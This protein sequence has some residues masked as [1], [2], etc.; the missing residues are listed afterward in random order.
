MRFG[1]VFS[2]LFA[3]ACRSDSDFNKI[4]DGN[5]GA[6]DGDSDT[7]ADV[8]DDPGTDTDD[9]EDS[10]TDDNEDS[11]TDDSG[12]DDSGTDDSGAD[13]DVDGDCEGASD[14]TTYFA[15][16]GPSLWEEAASECESK[17]MAFGSIRSTAENDF[18]TELMRGSDLYFTPESSVGEAVWLGFSDRAAEGVWVWED[19]YT[20]GFANWASGEPNDAGGQDCGY[21]DT[22]PAT[23]N[24]LWDD[25]GCGEV[26]GKRVFLCTRR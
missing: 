3:V 15:L 1:L 5:D 14:G 19:G 2:V 22:N 7:A 21:L 9:H 25:S 11:G 8:E 12:T 10:G 26:G 16:C 17:G 20:G 24:G 6:L 4:T 23:R 18:V 13:D